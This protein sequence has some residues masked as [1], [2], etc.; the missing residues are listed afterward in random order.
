L[1]FLEWDIKQKMEH[2]RVSFCGRERDLERINW[3]LHGFITK[4]IDEL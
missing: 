4:L 2:R 3:M 1:G